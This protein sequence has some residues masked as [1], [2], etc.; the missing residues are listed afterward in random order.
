MVKKRKAQGLSFNVIILAILGLIVLVVIVS[1]FSQQTGKSVE[2]LESCGGRGG[3]CD[4]GKCGLNELELKTV[5]CANKNPCCI[6]IFDK[7]EKK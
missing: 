2:T 7:D 5:E 4:K 1:I 6:P 3:D